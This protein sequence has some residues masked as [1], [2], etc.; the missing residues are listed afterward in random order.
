MSNLLASFNAGVSGLHSAQASLNTTSHNLA[1][2]QTTGY[3]RQQTVVT[4]S[5][6][7]KIMVPMV[8]LC[9]WERVPSLQ[10]PGRY[11]I[12]FLMNNIVFSLDGRVFIQRI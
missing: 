5:F 2:A 8:I 7:R 3:T 1:N 6:T 12:I 4:D 11:A 9:W 10:R